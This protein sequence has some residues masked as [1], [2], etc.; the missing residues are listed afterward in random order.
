MLR[1]CC[2]HAQGEI[3][4]LDLNCGAATADQRGELTLVETMRKLR[5]ALP[6]L[7]QLTRR[8][9]D[10]GDGFPVFPCESPS[11][12]AIKCISYINVFQQENV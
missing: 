3:I 12:D 11:V 10:R 9:C 8:F 4:A 1:L 2:V 7:V 5:P 6:V